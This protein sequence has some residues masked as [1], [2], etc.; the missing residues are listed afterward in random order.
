[1]SL[2][3]DASHNPPPEMVIIKARAF[4]YQY[5]KIPAVLYEYTVYAIKNENV[6]K[7]SWT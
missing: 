1:M 5:G 7:R 4:L 2:S 3:N 6:I